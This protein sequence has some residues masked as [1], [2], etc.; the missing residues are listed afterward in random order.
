MA[1][2]WCFVVYWSL[3]LQNSFSW[4]K[5]YPSWERHEG[6]YMMTVVFFFRWILPENIYQLNIIAWY[7]LKYKGN[8][9]SVKPAKMGKCSHW[10]TSPM[11]CVCVFWS[12]GVHH[13]F[14]GSL[15]LSPHSGSSDGLLRKLGSSYLSRFQLSGKTT[16]LKKKASSELNGIQLNNN[17]F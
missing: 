1:L 16:N 10:L 7:A 2:S 17:Q 13:V 14:Q 8:R 6:E 15:S 11:V 3:I 4:K 9:R 12:A 5:K